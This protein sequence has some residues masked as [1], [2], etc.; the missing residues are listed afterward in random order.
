MFLLPSSLLAV[1][2]LRRFN[3]NGFLLASVLAFNFLLLDELVWE[4][5]GLKNEN[6]FFIFGS[7]FLPFNG[8]FLFNSLWERY[9]EQRRKK[10]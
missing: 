9:Y 5:R 6:L 10:D 2:W 3:S 8:A 4:S 1:V 7:F